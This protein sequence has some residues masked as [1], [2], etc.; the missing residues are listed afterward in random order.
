MFT[1][2]RA[3]ARRRFPG[4][5]IANVK[6]TVT[7]RYQLITNRISKH[8][9]ELFSSFV[10]RR[11]NPERTRGLPQISVPTTL[12][13]RRENEGG[14]ESIASDRF[15]VER[16]WRNARSCVIGIRKAESESETTLRYTK[17]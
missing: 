13:R 3:R 10:G 1:R 12:R 7:Y 17:Y 2:A 8:I 11:L 14:R 4:I 15:R 16:D 6:E 9:I 5:P